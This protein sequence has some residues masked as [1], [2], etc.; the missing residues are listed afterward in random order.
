[1]KFKGKVI[2]KLSTETI[3]T[4]WWEKTKQSVVLEEAV[5][6]E[7]KGSIVID[8]WGDRVQQLANVQVWDVIDVSINSKSREY[9]WRWYNS[10]TW[11]KIETVSAPI[12]ADPA[13]PAWEYEDELPFS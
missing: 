11:W 2:N 8:F 4:G 13:A 1:M 7:Y 3:S 6:K 10:L 9:N 5:D 12:Q